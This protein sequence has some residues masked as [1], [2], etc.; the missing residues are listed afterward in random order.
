M[1]TFIHPTKSGGTALEEYF[2]LH[3]NK[4]IKGKKHDTLCTP[5]NNPILVLREPIDRFISMYK[6]WKNGSVD[7]N[8]HKRSEE[9]LK[10]YNNYSIKDF[11]NLIRKNS[12]RELHVTFTEKYHFAL[13]NY[14]INNTPYNKIIVIK[15]VKNLDMKM[16]QIL[17]ALGIP[18]KNIPLPIANVTI[19]KEDIILDE[20]DLNFIKRRF[21]DDFDL[22]NNVNNKKELFRMVL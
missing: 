10:K 8:V 6:Y 12:V 11:I 21:K 16:P 7:F 1:Y 3:Y 15:Y 14:W 13:T 22:Y 4:Y 20:D 17:K 9:F 18:D 5:T 2:A 19:S